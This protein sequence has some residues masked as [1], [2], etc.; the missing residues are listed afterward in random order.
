[1]F[2]KTCLTLFLLYNKYSDAETAVVPFQHKT[3]EENLH[4]VLSFD[5][6]S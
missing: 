2:A 5:T 4:S 1:M 3:V 6:I